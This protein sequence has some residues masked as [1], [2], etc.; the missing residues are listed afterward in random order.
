MSR[1]ITVV[2]RCAAKDGGIDCVLRKKTERGAVAG[3]FIA[4]IE[5]NKPQQTQPNHDQMKILK[6]IASAFSKSE[7]N[8]AKR[9]T[10]AHPCRAS[11][12]FFIGGL[13]GFAWGVIYVEHSPVDGI[14]AAIIGILSICVLAVPDL[15]NFVAIALV[16]S[17]IL[18]PSQVKAAPIAVCVVGILLLI[19]GCVAVKKG[20]KIAK[21]REFLLTNEERFVS[22]GALF[23]WNEEGN[24]YQERMVPSTPVV[25]TLHILVESLSNCTVTVR[26]DAGEQ[27][28]E[29][30]DEFKE[31]LPTF[32]LSWPESAQPSSCFEFNGIPCSQE[33]TGIYFDTETRTVTKDG[34][35]ATVVIERSTDLR[36]WTRLVASELVIGEDFSVADLGYEG[37]AFYR[38]SINPRAEGEARHP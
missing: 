2:F 4:A 13:V 5:S 27:Y 37:M 20:G 18:N 25:F 16:A 14:L 19:G 17:L 7:W 31:E 26:A 24:C 33:E 30:F 22:T 21:K 1:G 3:Q 29:S 28:V 9:W 10:V 32:G 8:K 6:H 36:T 15:K 38:T 35:D 34:S 12:Y 11:A 23:T